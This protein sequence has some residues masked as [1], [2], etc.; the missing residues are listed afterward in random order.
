MIM[1]TIGKTSMNWI[2][3]VFLLIIACNILNAQNQKP[4]ILLSIA[5][6]W[7]LHAGAYG[8]NVVKTP[9]FDKLAKE[10]VLF[11][12]AYV[13]APSCAPSRAAILTGQYHW[14]LQEGANLY[15]IIHEEDVI[16]T[17]MLEDAGYFVG[18]TRK[19]YGP[20]QK[21]W[22]ENNPAGKQYKDFETFLAERPKDKPFCFWFGS[23][24]PHRGYKLNSGAE[25]G[26]PIDSIEV[27]A[28]FPDNDVIRGDIADYYFEVQRFDRETGELIE[29][30]RQA[31]EMENTIVVMTSDHGMPFP[32]AKSNIYDDG[33]RVPLAIYWPQHFKGGHTVTD[34]VSLTDMAPTFLEAAGLKIPEIMTGRSLYPQLT[35]EKSGRVESSRDHILFGKERHVPSQPAPDSSGYP[36]RALRTDEYLLIRNFHPEKWP[37]GT[38]DYQNAFIPGM[39]YGDCDNGPTKYY[40][41]KNKDKDVH[42]KHLYDLSFAKRPEYE[43]YDM[44]KDPW[45]MK[46]LAY[47]PEYAAVFEKLSEQLNE[48]LKASKDPRVT[49]G[50]E[51]FD[52]Y[53]YTGWGPQYEQYENFYKSK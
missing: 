2:G 47:N 34:F 5:D 43:L 23:H 49:G 4:N 25:S 50:G 24:D 17:K 22:T 32:R 53:P 28:Y 29:L 36:C 44:I 19:G 42:H 20:M 33:A 39:W 27:P 18:Y 6:D 11:E 14:R 40:I 12:H 30:I 37:A 16:Y 45:Q 38:G 15:G 26:I 41:I 52:Q 51:K 48:E 10:G 31:G 9:V 8:D 35:A 1:K 46:N 3:T 21:G 13:S 7:G